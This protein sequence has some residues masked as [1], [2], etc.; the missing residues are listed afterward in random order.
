[1]QTQISLEDYGWNHPYVLKLTPMAKLAFFYVL[2]R[3]TSKREYV[4][5]VHMAKVTG[6]QEFL[7]DGYLTQFRVDRVFPEF[8]I[9]EDQEG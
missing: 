9:V 1:M 5:I 4:S 3:L 7:L 6:I 8:K 2:D